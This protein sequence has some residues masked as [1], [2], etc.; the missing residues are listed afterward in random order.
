MKAGE[1]SE[2][3]RSVQVRQ[4]QRGSQQVG[5]GPDTIGSREGRT[6]RWIEEGFKDDVWASVLSW[7]D[8]GVL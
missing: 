5:M 6:G 2:G 4:G 7:V 8:S 3:C 1:E